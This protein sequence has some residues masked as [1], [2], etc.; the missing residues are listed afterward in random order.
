MP[1]FPASIR[2]HTVLVY[3]RTTI[4]STNKRQGTPISSLSG[5]FSLPYDAGFTFLWRAEGTTITDNR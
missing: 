1:V 3:R 5:C 4:Y 2:V